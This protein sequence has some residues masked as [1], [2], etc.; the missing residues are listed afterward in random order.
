MKAS[1]INM[2]SSVLSLPETYDKKTMEKSAFLTEV[3]VSHWLSGQRWPVVIKYQKA[4]HC[5]FIS[6]LPWSR[7]MWIYMYIYTCIYIYMYI[8][9]YPSIYL[10]NTY[11]TYVYIYIQF[12]EVNGMDKVSLISLFKTWIL[13]YPEGCSTQWLQ[14]EVPN[15][16]PSRLIAW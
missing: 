13:E 4:F 8:Y 3:Q 16:S 7:S 11:V 2:S 1:I 10:Y 6:S 9:I 5:A 15:S 14:G 12:G